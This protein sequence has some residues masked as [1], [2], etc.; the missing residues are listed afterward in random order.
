MY[1]Q[2]RN[3]SNSVILGKIL[4]ARMTEHERAR[5]VKALRDADAIVNAILWVTKKFEWLGGRLFH[6]PYLKPSLKA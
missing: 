1:E 4:S 3:K 5:A 2:S 6:K